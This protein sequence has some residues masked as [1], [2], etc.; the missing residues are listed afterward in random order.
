MFVSEFLS[1]YSS[2]TA[3]LL[4]SQVQQEYAQFQ[5]MILSVPPPQFVPPG[6]P[7]IVGPPCKLK[8]SNFTEFWEHTVMFYKAFQSWNQNSVRIFVSFQVKRYFFDILGTVWVRIIARLVVESRLIT[9]IA[10]R[11]FLFG[12]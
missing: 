10:D 3:F 8:P 11:N 12:Y 6:I 1:F 2:N 5:Q 9:D 7:S 4:F